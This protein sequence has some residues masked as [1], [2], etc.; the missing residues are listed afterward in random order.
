MNPVKK[1]E[2]QIDLHNTV[3]QAKKIIE[4]IKFGLN[5]LSGA[6]SGELKLS[7]EVKNSTKTIL[8]SLSQQ[9]SGL[10]GKLP[11]TEELQEANKQATKYIRLFENL[12]EH[13]MEAIDFDTC[14][15]VIDD[16]ELIAVKEIIDTYEHDEG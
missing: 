11:T 14:C 9:L 16:N 15:E 12:I 8:F 4:S 2:E 6:V 10:F 7:D 3:T 13:L 5:V 1:L